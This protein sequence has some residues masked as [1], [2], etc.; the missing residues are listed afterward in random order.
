MGV[1]VDTVFAYYK[2]GNLKSQSFYK[3]NELNGDKIIYFPN[4]VVQARGSFV[5]GKKNGDWCVYD[6]LG[7]KIECVRYKH[8]SRND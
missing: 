1:I 2:N 8:G 7:V 4:G 6:S 5:N 3:D